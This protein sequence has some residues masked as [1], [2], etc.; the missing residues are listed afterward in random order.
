MLAW[1]RRK[2]VKM[3]VCRAMM[4]VWCN[5]I[6]KR[7]KGLRWLKKGQIEGIM[8]PLVGPCPPPVPCAWYGANFGIA[9]NYV[10]AIS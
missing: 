5:G 10:D 3:A 1:C 4:L 9:S 7:L 6:K 2:K 8:I